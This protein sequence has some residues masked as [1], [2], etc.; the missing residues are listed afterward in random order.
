MGQ[1]TTAAIVQNQHD[2]LLYEYAKRHM[3]KHRRVYSAY[4]LDIG[5]G[6]FKRAF[7]IHRNTVTTAGKRTSRTS[8]CDGRKK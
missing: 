2:C 6:A 1:K 4:Q 7:A 8:E 5:G 3:S